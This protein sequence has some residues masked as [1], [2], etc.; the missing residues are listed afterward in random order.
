MD[1]TEGEIASVLRVLVVDDSRLQRRILCASLAKLGYEVVDATDAESALQLTET[2]TFDVIFSDWMMPGMSGPEFCRI[3]R[4]KADQDRYTYFILLTSKSEKSDIAEGFDAGVDDFLTKPVNASE[5]RTRLSA[6]ERVVGMQHELVQKNQLITS[7][8]QEIQSLYDS[9]DHDLEQAKKLQQSLVKERH[10][11]YGNS[12]VS[13]LLRPAGHVGGDLVGFFPI[14]ANRLAIFGI[15]VAGH[16]IASALMTAR[17]AGFLSGSS[18]EQNIALYDNELGIYEAHPPHID[19]SRLN[20]LTIEELDA[21]TYFTLVFADVDLTTGCFDFVQAGH[22]YP[23]IQRANGDIEAIG[24]GGLPIGLIPGAE[25]TTANGQLRPGDRLLLASDGVTE[26]E[27]PDGVQL[28]ED[29]V[30]KLL[31]KN[32][33]LRGLSFLEAMVWDLER[34]AGNSDFADDVSAVLFEFDAGKAYLD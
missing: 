9:L 3:F 6:A 28:A 14:S 19:A 13:L 22:P 30:S 21:E 10:R 2:Q 11:S 34:Y 7:A 12:Q 15:D 4:E 23:M 31:K 25:F 29:G 32:T 33:D 17:L 18:V 16:G 24:E 20:Q 5:L 1:P 8:L 26:C 27:D